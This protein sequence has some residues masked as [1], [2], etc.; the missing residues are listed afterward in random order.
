MLNPSNPVV[1]NAMDPLNDRGSHQR[2]LMNP[3]YLNRIYLGTDAYCIE[4][5]AEKYFGKPASQLTLEE[6]A[7]LVG[8]IR[9]PR[10]YSPG[11]SP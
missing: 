9:S 3:N 1:N 7:V 5:G 10:V 2:F 6:T 11:G 4:A 8:M